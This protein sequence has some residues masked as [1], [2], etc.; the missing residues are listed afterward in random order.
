MPEA[1]IAQI[2]RT[3]SLKS[4]IRLLWDTIGYP[5]SQSILLASQGI[6]KE[7]AYM[8]AVYTQAQRFVEAHL[9]W[10]ILYVR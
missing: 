6:L 3:A 2:L 4:N 8:Y 7:Q 1:G 10:R 5:L 9:T